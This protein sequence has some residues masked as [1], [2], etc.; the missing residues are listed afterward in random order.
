MRRAAEL[1]ARLNPTTC[2]FDV[3]N[4]GI[5]QLTNIDIAGALGMVHEKMGRAVLEATAWDRNAPGVMSDLRR[6]LQAQVVE[7][8]RSINAELQDAAI[9]E[10]LS[11]DEDEIRKAR[12]N[13]D[14]LRA[15]ALPSKAEATHAVL[16]LVLFE[17]AFPNHCPVCHGRKTFRHGALV[18]DCSHCGATGRRRITD[19]DRAAAL[20]LSSGGYRKSRE[21]VL[22]D[23][24]ADAIGELL[25]D[26]ERQ[27]ADALDKGQ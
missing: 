24:L 1:L 20:K 4:G 2:R 26:A 14:R 3:G 13:T 19:D 25:H 5:P 27:L 17:L 18:V 7:R 15:M 6:M 22:R 12:Q 9:V 11:E 21:K 23:W 10:L 16:D 8:M